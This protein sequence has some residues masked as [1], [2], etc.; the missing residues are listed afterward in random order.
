MNIS[1]K[2]HYRIN[3]KRKNTEKITSRVKKKKKTS[4]KREGN[5]SLY[6]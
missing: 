5:I 1:V 4:N 2:S 3:I 6:F